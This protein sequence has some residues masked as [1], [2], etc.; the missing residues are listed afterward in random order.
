MPIAFHYYF[1]TQETNLSLTQ[2]FFIQISTD[3]VDGEEIHLTMPSES[4]V[5]SLVVLYTIVP[6]NRRSWVGFL[7]RWGNS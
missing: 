6:L 4:E 3:G 7:L 2:H 5:S 1:F